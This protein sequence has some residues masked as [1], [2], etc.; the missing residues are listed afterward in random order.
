MKGSFRFR[1]KERITEPQD[2]RR[3]MKLGRRN[4]S[5][6]FMLF[7]QESEETFHR[8]GIVVKKEIGPAAFRNR[9][10]RYIREFFRLHKHKINGSYDIILMIKKGCSLNRYQEAEEEL[11]GL[12][13]L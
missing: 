13:I 8:L 4:S 5:R 7:I 12:F 2:F 9:M 10:K 1:K 11:R 6:N 3:V